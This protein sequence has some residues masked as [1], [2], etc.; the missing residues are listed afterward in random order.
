M[1]KALFNPS[2]PVLEEYCGVLK[3][4]IYE[5]VIGSG[6]VPGTFST[7]LD[8]YHDKWL[9]FYDRYMLSKGEY[10][11]LYDIGFDFPEGHVIRKDGSL[12]YAFYTNPWLSADEGRQWRFG[13]EFDSKS[14][15][16]QEDTENYTGSF[17]GILHLRGLNNSK[18]YHVYDMV[19]DIELSPVL[20]SDPYISLN[21][22]TFT[23]LKVTPE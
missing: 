20:G 4:P 13:T 17:E 8:E 11:N 3:G 6:G 21:F 10:L 16:R 1:Y 7:N 14:D 2:V 5:L 23:M 22:D 9:K 18:T 19:N 12:Y 15:G